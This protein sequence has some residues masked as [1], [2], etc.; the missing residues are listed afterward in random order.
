LPNI[1]LPGTT[2]D[3]AT[4][5]F[6]GPF[7]SLTGD[8]L[9]TYR[10]VE[11]QAGNE[12]EPDLAVDLPQLS[13]DGKTYRF[14]LRPNVHY[15][16]GKLV[17]ASDV[18]YTFERVLRLA[19][20]GPPWMIDAFRGIR[21][22]KSC[23]SHRCDLSAGVVT[24]DTARTVTFHLYAPDPD[25]RYKLASVSATIV[26][27][28]TPMQP[29]TRRPVP[30][31]GPYRLASFTPNQSVRLVRNPHFHEWSHAAQPA[32]FPDEIVGEVVP[33]REQPE[34]LRIR[35]QKERIALV[36][37]GEAD[38]TS[39][40]GAVPFF[41]LVSAP[42]LSRLH[43]YPNHVVFYLA[44]NTNRPPFNDSRARRAVNY[45]L[46]RNKVVELAAGE[47]ANRPTCQVLPP[48][49]PAYRR[50]C[51]YTRPSA[52][53]AWTAPDSTR[54]AGLVAASGTRRAPVTLWVPREPAGIG[55]GRYLEGLLSSLGYRVHL[56]SSFKAL[57]DRRTE[58][59]CSTPTSR[60]RW[61]E[62]VGAYF[63]AVDKRTPGNAPQ[64]LWS[65]WAAD[66]PGAS[67]FIRA[68]FSCGS[69]DKVTRSCDRTLDRP[70]R[71]ALQLQQ[72]DVA[73]AN[74]LWT[75]LDHAITDKAL[76]VPLYN[77]YGADLV[78]KR[79]GNY[80]YNPREGALLSQ[81]WVR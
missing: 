31:T 59:P 19:Q 50:Y 29:A 10:Q 70:I 69:K 17:R 47:D 18:R 57:L 56:R 58:E 39:S 80:R 25:F 26:P 40:H 15:S 78:S 66:Y 3:P 8:G 13:P 79:V 65:G 11:G 2:F 41:S 46:D 49:F 54:A 12:L 34:A 1:D 38:L 52:D 9:L 21:G 37:R 22:A 48:N 64:I 6:I 36:E 33:A 68:L 27:A 61:T 74:R 71:R 60:C 7:L 51:P 23:N 35:G 75:Q 20:F 67:D 81:L 62:S 14:R 72:T 32:G 77:V 53:G 4:A 28:G 76:W 63:G 73:G 42:S 30:A 55:L 45:A 16:N 24:D 5:F 43:R 44:F